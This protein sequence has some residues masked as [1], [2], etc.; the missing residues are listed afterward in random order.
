MLLREQGSAL[1]RSLG[2]PIPVFLTKKMH[3]LTRK[4]FNNLLTTQHSCP[5]S[6]CTKCKI[7]RGIKQNEPEVHASCFPTTYSSTA[8][9]TLTY[10]TLPPWSPESGEHSRPWDIGPPQPSRGSCTARGL[11]TLLCPLHTSLCCLPATQRYSL[12]LSCKVLSH[13]QTDLLKTG[14]TGI[15][16]HAK[17]PIR[18]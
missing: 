3:F 17:L 11:A 4:F 15:C 16:R 5:S 18:F 8:W 2:E 14:I 10:H 7:S 12:L 1:T 6:I 9:P 13:S